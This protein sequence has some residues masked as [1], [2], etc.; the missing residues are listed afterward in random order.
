[1]R[2][3]IID[4]V[5]SFVYNIVQYVGELGV[6]PIVYRNDSNLE[7]VKE[8]NPE[9]V[10][11]SPGPKTPEEAGISTNV[12]RELGEEVPILGVC[13]GH[14]VIAYTFGGD[15]TSSEE[16]MHGKTSEIIY[17]KGEL[18]DGIPNPFEATRYHSLVVKDS[19]LPTCLQVTARADEEHGGI[20]GIEHKDYPIFGVQFHPES[21]LTS[22]GMRILK[23]FLERGE[24]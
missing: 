16:L 10:I 3:V 13:L 17:F 11:I 5:D 19:T 8:E 20:M 1:M 6:E 14:Q 24:Y 18:Y 23:N 9:R 2:V 7:D 21:I 12:V 15:I 22:Y 4:N